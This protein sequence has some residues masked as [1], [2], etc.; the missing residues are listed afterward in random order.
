VTGG[1]CPAV[2]VLQGQRGLQSLLTAS[3]L[4]TVS[5]TTRHLSVMS[6]EPTAFRPGPYA[7]VARAAGDWSAHEEELARLGIKVSQPPTRKS[8]S[9]VRGVEI[10]TVE[11]SHYMD[12][13]EWIRCK[14]STRPITGLEPPP[15][16]FKFKCDGIFEDEPGQHTAMRS[17]ARCAMRA[18]NC[19]GPTLGSTAFQMGKCMICGVRGASMYECYT[20]AV[21]VCSLCVDNPTGADN[22]FGSDKTFAG[23]GDARPKP[24]SERA[25]ADWPG[26]T[27]PWGF[28]PDPLASTPSG[29][30]SS[31]L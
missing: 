17:L 22:P 20:H 26:S 28:D 23:F 25:A 8:K 14:V 7:C 21:V 27:I 30:P 11:Q 2:G 1:T 18:T 5:L 10:A 15:D 19:R 6:I 12:S 31:T 29:P 16:G 24:A 4:R 3:Y 13:A 9:T